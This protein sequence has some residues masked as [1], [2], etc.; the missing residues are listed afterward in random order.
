MISR[1]K[2]ITLLDSQLKKFSGTELNIFQAMDWID[3][4]TVKQVIK[5]CQN[6]EE[7]YIKLGEFLSESKSSFNG[8]SFREDCYDY[9]ITKGFDDKEAFDFMEIIR[10]GKYRFEKHQIKSDK[11]PDDFCEW[12][13]CVKY[14]P[15][16]NILKDMFDKRIIQASNY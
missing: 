12:A 13:K 4:D 11:L 7:A 14:L 16:R 3:T 8:V 15:S 6:G 2:I 1:T 5:D 10:K 9:L